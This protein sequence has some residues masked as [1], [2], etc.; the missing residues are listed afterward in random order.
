MCKKCGI[1]YPIEFF[2]TDKNSRGGRRNMCMECNKVKCRDYR[3]RHPENWYNRYHN[4]PIERQKL[5]ARA[6]VRTRVFTGRMERG[7]CELCGSS[8][9]IHGHHENYDNPFNVNWLCRPCHE[10]LHR[11]RKFMAEPPTAIEGAQ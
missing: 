10:A 8:H 4:N 9:D 2:L 1:R 7:V 6:L 11:D 5:D 3:Q